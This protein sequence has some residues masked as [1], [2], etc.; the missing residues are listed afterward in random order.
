MVGRWRSKASRLGGFLLAIKITKTILLQLDKIL[1]G[2]EALLRIIH[3]VEQIAVLRFRLEYT[4]FFVGGGALGRNTA[5][6]TNH[7]AKLGRFHQLAVRSTGC[8]RDALVDQGAAEVIG[9]GKKRD[10][11][12]LRSFLAPG[13]LQIGNIIV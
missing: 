12:K 3:L 1:I 4:D 9:S 13:D 8:G 11:R 7:A 2:S 6:F 10:L 5:H